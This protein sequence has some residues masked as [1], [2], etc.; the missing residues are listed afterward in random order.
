MWPLLC[1][2]I[3][4]LLPLCWMFFFFFFFYHNRVLYLTKCFFLH[5]LIWSCDYC[6][7]FCLCNVC[8]YCAV[9]VSLG[10]ISLDHGVYIFLIYCWMW[11]SITLLRI[12]GLC[13]S[14]ILACSFLSFL[15]L[16]LV[17]GLG[18]CCPHKK[19][20]VAFYLLGFFG[21]VWEW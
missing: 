3:F 18:W 21:I 16:G 20:L 6:L 1:L 17:W 19:S 11:F 13:S 10:W 12:L 14:V 15:C 2:G 9:L 4:L 5:L 8:K 7:S